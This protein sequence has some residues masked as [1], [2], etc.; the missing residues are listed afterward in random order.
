MK[1]EKTITINGVTFELGKDIT[2]TDADANISRLKALYE[3]YARPSDT[4]ESIYDY[5]C[6]WFDKFI[7]S[8]YGVS[9]YNCNFFTM[10]GT[11]V[12][13]N[14]NYVAVITRSHNRLY[15]IAF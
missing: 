4:K 3:C 12:Y 13:N 5:W 15:R 8:I 1:R 2:P 7:I 9:S 11:F 10:T 14:V 6:K